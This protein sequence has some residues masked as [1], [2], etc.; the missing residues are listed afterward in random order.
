MSSEKL[1]LLP[2]Q[3]RQ[4][5]ASGRERRLLQ[6]QGAEEKAKVS[7]YGTFAELEK[8]PP[9]GLTREVVLNFPLWAGP[10]EVQKL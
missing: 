9:L 3:A 10:E 4:G 8:A 1:C 5:S 6:H 2:G 7:P